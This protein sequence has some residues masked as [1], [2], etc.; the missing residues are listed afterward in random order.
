MNLGDFLDKHSKSVVILLFVVIAICFGGTLV[1]GVFNYQEQK[2]YLSVMV[3]PV[4]A[5]VTLN[6]QE[7][8]MGLNEIEPG[9]Y[10][11]KISA[12]GFI[13]KEFTLEVKHGEP[14]AVSGYLMHAS[15]GINYYARDAKSL[16]VLRAMSATNDEQLAKFLDDYSNLMGIKN[17]LPMDA[18]F[19]KG[20]Q[21]IRVTVKD[22]SRDPRCKMAFCLIA[23]GEDINPG[24]VE[25][26]VSSAGFDLKNYEV[27]YDYVKEEIDEY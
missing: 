2:T 18:S 19:S 5:R 20:N 22:G 14:A 6:D 23:V 1:L 27:I 7:Y 10:Q 11:V 12:D 24:A 26:A 16:S 25:F 21:E 17:S 3:A 13:S 8:Q 4:F 9:K 15:E